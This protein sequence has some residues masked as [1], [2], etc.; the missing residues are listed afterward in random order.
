MSVKENWNIKDKKKKELWKEL[1]N[2]KEN[3]RKQINHLAACLGL[4][5]KNCTV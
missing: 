2:K 1:K 4:L 3:A 5:T